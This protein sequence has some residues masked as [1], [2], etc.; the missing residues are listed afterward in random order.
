MAIK[1][2]L[3]SFLAVLKRSNLLNEGQVA[4]ALEKFRT[5][6]PAAGV[7]AKPFAEFLVRNKVL[8]VWQAEKVLQG[9]HKGFFLG[10][11][12][13]LSLLGKGGMS[14]VY[15]AEHTVMKRRCA[16]KVL[17]AKR[18]NDASYLGRF[19]REAQAV[20]ALDHPNIVRAYDVDMTQDAGIDIH[21]LSM[22]FVQ[23]K[24]LLEL[25]QE[26]GPIPVA[27]AVE[28]IRQS[29]EGLDHAHKAG[30]VH[31]DIKP[32]NLLL[33]PGGVIKILDL[34]LARF[35]NDEEASLTVEHDEKVLGTAD[36]I[37][38]EQ[39]IDSHKVDHRTDIYSLGCT[40][41]FL[42]TGHPPFNSGSLAQRLIAHQTKPAPPITAERPDVPVSLIA[43]MDKMMAKKEP[44]RHQ[45][46]QE[47]ADA[48]AAWQKRSPAE[49][50]AAAKPA[51]MAPAA[52]ITSEKAA[53]IPVAHATD[54]GVKSKVRTVA[55]KSRSG[56]GSSVVRGKPD[57]PA[58]PVESPDAAVDPFG[59]LNDLNIEAAPP[60]PSDSKA[61]R[62][63]SRKLNQAAKET[64]KL[65]LSP[66][67]VSSPTPVEIDEPS[68]WDQAFDPN[69]L[70]LE[71]PVPEGPLDFD[72]DAE[73]PAPAQSEPVKQEIKKPAT[74]FDA[75]TSPK[76]G[77]RLVRAL[78]LAAVP[79]LATAFWVFRDDLFPSVATAP[80]QSPQA[81]VAPVVPV[82]PMKPVTPEVAVIE[83]GP[84][85][86]FAT[87]SEAINYVR[88]NFQPLTETDARTI[89]LK[90]G[91]TF[92]ESVRIVNE[93]S[94]Y[95]PRSVTI[96]SDG[97]PAIIK[98]NGKQPALT[99][100]DVDT[101]AIDGVSFDG[102]SAAVAVSVVGHC[103]ST[104]LLNLKVQN[105]T[106]TA[107]RLENLSGAAGQEFLIDGLRITANVP[108][109]SGIRCVV[110]LT[111]NTKSVHLRNCRIVGPL[112]SGLEV[113][114]F[115]WNAVVSDS[116]F[117]QCQSGVRFDGGLI[118]DVA[119]TNCS[120]YKN[121]QAISFAKLP[122][123]ESKNLRLQQLLFSGSQT[124]DVVLESGDLTGLADKLL[125][126]P[127]G[128]R[129]NRTDRKE[130]DSKELDVFAGD[131]QRGA[132]I[133]FTSVD[134]TNPGYLKAGADLNVPNPVP[135][136]KG[137][138]GAVAP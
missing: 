26:K 21:F 127:D 36:Y 72:L 65:S 91:L 12:R 67:E 34:G 101:L 104:R 92:S 108:T 31:R 59:F 97:S 1:I 114:G 58:A 122:G 90:G 33:T 81:P 115:F 111:G 74:R 82:T 49:T 35:F 136:S 46:A 112:K 62:S 25:V 85:G 99:L 117:A 38:P 120:F 128:R 5:T 118:D 100:Q 55:T 45:T 28:Y 87:V 73:V 52:V 6:N 66:T 126:G 37:S 13:L 10:R 54:S 70:N 109:A 75:L 51:L 110:S 2:T 56:T 63:S 77:K 42:L 89:L 125:G 138:V 48:L 134:P 76:S 17:P 78:L 40:L 94:T 14:S 107:V 30:L 130:P 124:G 116:I 43:I 129:L 7:D 102:N 93:D 119:L 27:D 95:F 123:D 47:V 11:Y 50:V 16:L 64:A 8:T 9:K 98:G 39:A 41:Y 44:D 86:H 105:F 24:S 135:G 106:E 71:E 20:A 32:G 137:Y 60:S 103:P 113:T 68:A 57:I 121:A 29:A 131:G 133:S 3:D 15:L 22:E 18:V 69:L 88:K 79:I 132:T 84:E 19:H 4:T 61:G 96:K 53:E 80:D 23:G 83:V